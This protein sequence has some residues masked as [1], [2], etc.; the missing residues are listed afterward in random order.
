M[1]SL[2]PEERVILV[3]HSLGG[4]GMSVVMERFPEKIS[5]AV[6]VTALMP[7]PNLTFI[8][9]SKEFLRRFGSFMDSQ[10]RYD[11]GPNN[12]P[13]AVKFGPNL[14]KSK[15]YQLSPPEDLFLALSLLRPVPFFNDEE[16]VL[17][18]TKLTKGNYGSVRRVFIVTDQDLTIGESLQRLMIEQNPP[19]E[20][21]VINRT[22]HMVLFTRPTKLFSYLGEIAEKYY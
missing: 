7:G 11:Q 16:L 10:Y 8:T 2:K 17:K 20:V 19:N 6:F 5:A 9:I 12:P 21:K 18:Q 22:D 1:A 3:G 4:L 15:F 13:T 14:L